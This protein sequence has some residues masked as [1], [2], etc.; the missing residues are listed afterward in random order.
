MANSIL[1]ID[2]NILARIQVA[3][4]DPLAPTAARW[5]RV[6][7]PVA[8]AVGALLLALAAPQWMRGVQAIA[9]YELP[10]AGTVWGWLTGVLF[11]PVTTVNPL[12]AQVTQTWLYTGG[13]MNVMTTLGTIMLA[14]ASVAGLGQLLG[15]EH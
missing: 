9:A 7:V 4:A 1:V 13:P 10:T 15:S 12:L 2:D 14:V 11:D 3:S 8:F 5:R 6:W